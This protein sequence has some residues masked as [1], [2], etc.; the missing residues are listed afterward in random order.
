MGGEDCVKVDAGRIHRSCNGVI[1]DQTVTSIDGCKSGIGV[2]VP[3]ANSQGSSHIDDV[4]IDIQ[5]VNVVA[6]KAIERGHWVIPVILAHVPH[7]KTT[8]GGDEDM[9]GGESEVVDD[10]IW[11]TGN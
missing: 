6:G 4:L 3:A 7:A 9:G 5:G 8:F 2:Q 11:Q 1:S 10:V